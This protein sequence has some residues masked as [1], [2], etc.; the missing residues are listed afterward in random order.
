MPKNSARYDHQGD[1]RARV[2]GQ[3]PHRGTRLSPYAAIIPAVVPVAHS[4]TPSTRS[5]HHSVMRVLYT[6]TQLPA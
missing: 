5:P 1:L 3:K 2:S 4:P 6:S